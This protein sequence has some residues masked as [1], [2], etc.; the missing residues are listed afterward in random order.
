MPII[1]DIKCIIDFEFTKNFCNDFR[2]TFN[3]LKVM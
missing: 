1:I 2:K 3:L